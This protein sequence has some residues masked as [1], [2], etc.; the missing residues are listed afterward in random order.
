MRDLSAD[1]VPDAARGLANLRRLR[2]RS[3]P[4]PR[5]AVLIDAVH[6]LG[7][8][9]AALLGRDGCHVILTGENPGDGGA[10]A[11]RLLL[12]GV[13]ASSRFLDVDDADQLRRFADDIQA[14][15]TK[16]DVFVAFAGGAARGRRRGGVSSGRLGSADPDLLGDAVARSVSR[17]VSLHRTMLPLMRARVGRMIHVVAGSEEQASNGT[18]LWPD[19]CAASAV[20]SQLVRRLGNEMREHS[21]KVGGVSLASPTVDSRREPGD[22][23]I[24]RCAERIATLAFSADVPQGK[25][26]LCD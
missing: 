25:I 12:E 6:P 10:I 14:V 22:W 21:V 19:A 11:E 18:T 3:A 15:Y 1:I 26:Y 16:L 7:L 23:L 20:V 9:T 4:Q 17:T 13:A 24:Q 2:T 5:S 8:R